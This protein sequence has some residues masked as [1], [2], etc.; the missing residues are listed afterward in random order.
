MTDKKEVVTQQEQQE[1]QLVIGAN[2][3]QALLN[4]LSTAPTGDVP[5]ITVFNLTQG[6]QALQPIGFKEE[7]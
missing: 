7:K 6:L 5:F 1:P 3:A 2:L 4:H